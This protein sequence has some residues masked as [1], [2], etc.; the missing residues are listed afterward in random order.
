M[1]AMQ[2]P[3][4]SPNTGVGGPG[5]P[6]G[7]EEVVNGTLLAPEERPRCACH[8]EPQFWNRDVRVADGGYWRCAVAG[9]EKARE[10]M[11]RLRERRSAEA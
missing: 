6:N 4:V 5:G 10:R 3:R 8:G 7:T 9:R 11:R 1:N 2:I